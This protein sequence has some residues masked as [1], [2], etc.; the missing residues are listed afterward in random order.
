M[1]INLWRGFAIQMGALCILIFTAAFFGYATLAMAVLGFYFGLIL[2]V[3]VFTYILELFVWIIEAV[4][5]R[6]IAALKGGKIK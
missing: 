1:A 2:M 3:G 4:S 6:V 5:N